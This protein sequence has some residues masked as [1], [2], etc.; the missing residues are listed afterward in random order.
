[1]CGKDSLHFVKIMIKKTKSTIDARMQNHS[2]N[3]TERLEMKNDIK[4]RVQNSNGHKNMKHDLLFYLPSACL[5]QN[6]LL[7]KGKLR[8]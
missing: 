6:N 3:K 1:M 5:M 7:P 4:V 2:N 8:M